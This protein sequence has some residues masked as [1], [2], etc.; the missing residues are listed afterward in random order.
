MSARSFS[1]PEAFLLAT[2]SSALSTGT[3]TP[4]TGASIRRFQAPSNVGPD[5][6]ETGL[7]G[8]ESAEDVSVVLV[9]RFRTYCSPSVD[10]LTGIVERV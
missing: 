10:S 5:H 7:F 2:R 4:S 6:E 3:L 8:D 1:R 9:H